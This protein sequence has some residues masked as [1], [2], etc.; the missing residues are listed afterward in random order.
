M[1]NLQ[2]G[3]IILS[4]I[5]ALLWHNHKCIMPSAG[6]FSRWVFFDNVLTTVAGQSIILDDR[7]EAKSLNNSNEI[8]RGRGIKRTE[9]PGKRTAADLRIGII[10]GES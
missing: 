10:S 5:K 9:R 8:L 7:S 4:D 6:F 3:K 1:A 2:L